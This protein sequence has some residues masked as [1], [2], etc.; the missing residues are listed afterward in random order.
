M[1]RTH[2]L[3]LRINPVPATPARA[4]IQ[5]FSM[6]SKRV[7]CRAGSLFCTRVCSPCA[8]VSPGDAALLSVLHL[9]SWVPPFLCKPSWHAVQR[10]DSEGTEG[11]DGSCESSCAWGTR[12]RSLEHASH[13]HTQPWKRLLCA[14]TLAVRARAESGR[15]QETGR[16]EQG[17]ESD[18]PSCQCLMNNERVVFQ[19]TTPANTRRRQTISAFRQKSVLKTSKGLHLRREA[20]SQ[21][22]ELK[23]SSEVSETRSGI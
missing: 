18:L 5:P 8:C 23:Y 4:L 12:L 2:E 13:E 6:P 20:T 22:G 15:H 17:Y 11:K 9:A 10:S 21:Q 16:A 3:W 14:D 1:K 7:I 19:D